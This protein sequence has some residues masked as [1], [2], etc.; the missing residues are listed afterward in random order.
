MNIQWYP[1]HMTKA[2]RE[3]T[4]SLKL[5]ELV[6]ELLDA[7]IPISSRNPDIDKLCGNK[8][9]LIVLNKSDLADDKITKIWIQYFKGIGKDCIEV[10]SLSGKNVKTIGRVVQDKFKER[11]KN[12]KAK[13]IVSKPI[14]IMIAGVPNVGKS[15]LIN[16]LSGR[17]SA[18]TGDKPGVTRGKQWIKLGS[19]MELL[20]T[21]GILWP[22][23]DDPKVGYNLAFTGAIKDEILDT[24]EL[25]IKLIDTLI[26]I[27][28]ESIVSR[29]NLKDTKKLAIEILEDI[30]KVRGCMLPGGNIDIDRAASIV[31]DE[32]RS[33][34]LGRISLE[35][36]NIK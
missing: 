2:R 34:K 31:L 22:K 29:Y 28:P 16:R 8:P 5:V 35:K 6:I 10:D 14:R 21:P 24:A 4:E 36:P 15:S 25:S 32:F 26:E 19:N 3:M 12:L 27:C 30:G 33:G 13:G 17:A 11:N 18:K 20:D 23:F 7:R 1:G 9:R